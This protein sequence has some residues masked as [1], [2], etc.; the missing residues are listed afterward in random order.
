MVAAWVM[1]LEI[2]RVSGG[3][4]TL[5]NLIEHLLENTPR[6]Q[7]VS[8]Q[9]FV[10]A[11]GSLVGEKAEALYVSLI[12]SDQPIPLAGYLKDTQF[13]IVAGRIFIKE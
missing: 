9:E 3:K 11:L 8:R 12:E 5:K 6:D 4:K 13:S 1:D 10:A 2:Q 7:A